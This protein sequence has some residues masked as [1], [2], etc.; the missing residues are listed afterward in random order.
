M[1]YM[2]LLTNVYGWLLLTY[3][4]IFTNVISIFGY[5]EGGNIARPVYLQG[6]HPTEVSHEESVADQ[7]EGQQETAL[8]VVR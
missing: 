8:L 7:S 5:V 1:S 4:F 3:H 6:C 2:E